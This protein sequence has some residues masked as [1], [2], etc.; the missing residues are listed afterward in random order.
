MTDPS[1]TAD[2]GPRFDRREMLIVHDVFRREFALMPITSD[3]CPNQPFL[4]FPFRAHRAANS[5][6][7][8]VGES[9]Y[10]VAGF[11]PVEDVPAD[12]VDQR[13]LGELLDPQRRRPLQ[14]TPAGSAEFA[15][16]VV[17]ATHRVCETG[18][19]RPRP[20]R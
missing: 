11:D 13:E 1:G 9:P 16:D 8:L 5:R 10:D 3:I 19:R 12:A 2:H 20:R 6:D 17:D 4:S 7:D 18:R 14:E 15:A